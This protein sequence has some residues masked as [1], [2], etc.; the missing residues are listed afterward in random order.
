MVYGGFENNLEF[1]Q[2]VLSRIAFL[3]GRIGNPGCM[4]VDIGDGSADSFCFAPELLGPGNYYARVFEGSEESDRWQQSLVLVRIARECFAE[5]AR[6]CPDQYG[7]N[8]PPLELPVAAGLIPP[9]PAYTKYIAIL[10]SRLAFNSMGLRPKGI[11]E[12]FQF[13]APGFSAHRRFG[14]GGNLA[15]VFCLGLTHAARPQAAAAHI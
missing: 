8:A 5:A 10:I 7:G 14:I 6:I 15:A 3:H 12:V 4:Q 11:N 13:L 1:I 9:T 2:P